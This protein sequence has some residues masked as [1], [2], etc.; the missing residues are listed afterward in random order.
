MPI[1]YY[2][3]MPKTRVI[4]LRSVWGAFINSSENCNWFQFLLL[5]QSIYDKFNFPITEILYMGGLITLF[6]PNLL[7][8]TQKQNKLFEEDLFQ[9]K[10]ID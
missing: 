1:P 4:E 5:Q 6:P 9:M 3:K 10:K 8:G 2:Y 7:L